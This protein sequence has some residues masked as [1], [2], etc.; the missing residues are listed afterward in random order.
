MSA[1]NDT[2][3]SVPGLRVGHAQ[4]PGGGSG[5]T[6]VLGPFRAAAEV[7]GT[8]SGTRELDALDPHHLVEEI[9]ALLLTG[10]SAF[11]LAAADGVVGWLEE[12]G[13]G[14]ATRVVP[15]PIVPAAVLYDLAP[16]VERPGPDTGRAA[17]DAATDAPVPAGRVGAGTGARV[18]KIAG[19][20][21]ASPGGVG[22]AATSLEGWRVGALAVVN[23]VGDVVDGTGRIVAGARDPDGGFLDSVRLVGEGGLRGGFGGRERAGEA[24][25][26]GGEGPA[27]G[28]GRRDAGDASAGPRPGENTTL[29]V[30]ATD[31]P[32]GPVELGRMLRTAGAGLARRI[33]PSFTPFDGDICFALSTAPGPAT[34]PPTPAEVLALGSVAARM[35]EE[36]VLRAVRP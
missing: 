16:D 8:A 12:R 30:V 18:G 35:L 19:P 25:A 7:R 36:A 1:P 17:C 3:T 10:G 6:V 27:G 32:L 5:C 28:R 11:G 33:V 2:L 9:D 26:P 22:S 29:A 13:R 23:A 21:W 31:A 20:E 15:V 4:V 24:G 34:P 14:F